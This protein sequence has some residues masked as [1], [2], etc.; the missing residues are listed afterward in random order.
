[1]RG[2]LCRCASKQDN[3]L[4]RFQ[5]LSQVSLQTRIPLLNAVSQT[6]VADVR[7]RL[8]A[9][10]FRFARGSL[11]AGYL[12]SMP[13]RQESN[14]LA[15]FCGPPEADLYGILG[16]MVGSLG[17]RCATM[18]TPI[19]RTWSGDHPWFGFVSL[20]RSRH[21]SCTTIRVTTPLGNLC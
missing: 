14:A 4:R 1:M 5:H 15:R 19:H 11:P 21:R 13:E 3:R 7:L 18:E 16:K 17:G 9:V 12:L 2:R 20:S 6:L 8:N 10:S